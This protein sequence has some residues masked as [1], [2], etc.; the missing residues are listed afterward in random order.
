MTAAYGVVTKI[1]KKRISE[2]LVQGR[3]LDGR[4]LTDYREIKVELGLI[5]KAAGSALVSLG[6]TKVLAGI[7]IETG[8][9]FPDTPNEGVLIVNAELVPLASPS[10]EPGPPSENSIELSRV[11]D[12]GIRESKAIDTKKL[13]IVSGKKVFLVYVDIYILDHDGN[14]FDASALASISAL[15]NAKMKEFTVEDGELKFKESSIKLPVSN[16][17][18]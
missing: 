17:P 8:Q 16:Y 15:L 2:L 12:R 13:C 14:L 1:K 7:K 18:V 9:P 11:V 3:R 10:F 6:N 4:G 5:G